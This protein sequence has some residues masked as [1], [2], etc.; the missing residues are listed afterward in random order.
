MLNLLSVFVP[1]WTPSCFCSICD[2]LSILSS[3][4]TSI[5]LRSVSK[6]FGGITDS[7]NAPLISTEAG[8]LPNVALSIPVCLSRVPFPNFTNEPTIFC[9]IAAAVSKT[10]L[11]LF[12][13]IDFWIFLLNIFGPS[14]LIKFTSPST[15][16][17]IKSS[18]PPISFAWPLFFIC[19]SYIPSTDPVNSNFFPFIGFPE[20]SFVSYSTSDTRL[21]YLSVK[22][23][24]SFPV[25]LEA[26]S[27]EFNFI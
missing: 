14:N 8:S 16:A 4:V 24:K 23:I 1:P 12:F 26:L 18:S 22:L 6:R 17:L 10:F 9:S 20:E 7:N 13:N 25:S 21:L 27:K 5:F 11:S 15:E 2:A 3:F 19:S